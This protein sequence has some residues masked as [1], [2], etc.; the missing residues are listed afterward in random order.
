MA[1]YV[2]VSGISYFLPII[3]FL[4]VS[5]IM[6]AVL[7]KLKLFD[8]KWVLAIVSFFIA[9]LFITV[10]GTIDYIKYIGAWI[11]ILFVSMA[12]LLAIIGM[13]GKSLEGMTKGI[14]IA[15][16]IVAILVFLISAFVVYSNF[17]TPY[18]P[19]GSSVGDNNTGGAITNW[20]Y[21]P[22]VAGAILLLV[23]SGLAAWF[24]TK[25]K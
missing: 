17:I 5:F 14:G 10:S 7:T 23:I 22:R 20:L 25:G 18:L 19:G 12:F 11:A 2:D 13:F 15:V 6:F 24:L 9:T 21:S 8:A 1:T 16:L 4:L 3:A